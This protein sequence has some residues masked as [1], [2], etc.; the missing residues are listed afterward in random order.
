MGGS[1]GAAGGNESFQAWA[2]ASDN[3]ANFPHTQWNEQEFR[4]LLE[5]LTADNEACSETINRRTVNSV[6][7][8][9]GAEDEGSPEPLEGFVQVG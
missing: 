7:A 9:G 5:S 8:S 1:G 2:E 6:K 4:L 3:E